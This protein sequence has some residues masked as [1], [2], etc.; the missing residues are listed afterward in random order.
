MER[1]PGELSNIGGFSAEANFQSKINEIVKFL[2]LVNNRL[3]II[4]QTNMI[5]VECSHMD[6]YWLNE[7]KG[8]KRCR[9]C[10][11]IFKETK[12]ESNRGNV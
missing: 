4:E 12:D 9:S 1:P 7:K 6:V 8:M 10:G 3:E 5:P 2:R 11:K